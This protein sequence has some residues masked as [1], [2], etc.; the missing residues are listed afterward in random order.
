[1]L[2]AAAAAAPLQAAS[3]GRSTRQG[4]CRRGCLS[5]LMPMGRPILR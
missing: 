3:G 2:A 1:M 5:T 4:E